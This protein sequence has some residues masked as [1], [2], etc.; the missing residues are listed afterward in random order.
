MF[1]NIKQWHVANG[2]KKQ[3]SDSG[4]P[5]T[6]TKTPDDKRGGKTPDGERNDKTPSPKTKHVL[7]NIAMA[8]AKKLFMTQMSK[9]RHQAQEKE[10]FKIDTPSH[11]ETEV[12]PL[13]DAF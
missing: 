8:Q 5:K 11:E 1:D 12:A 10:H 4:A 13:L 9:L 3:T 7:F 2:N 6:I